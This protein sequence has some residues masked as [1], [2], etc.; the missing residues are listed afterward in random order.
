MG[1]I[2]L[3]VCLISARGLRQSTILWNRHWFAVGWT[4]PKN[5]YCTKID[6]SGSSNPVWK[7]KFSTLLDSD[8]GSQ[9]P[10]LQD[11]VLQ[12]E[13]Y[14][15]DPVFL[16]EKLQG[17][18]SIALREFLVKLHRKSEASSSVNGE[19]GSY[20][21]RKKGSGKPRGFVDVSIRVSEEGAEPSFYTG[22]EGG[23]VLMD[24]NNHHMDLGSENALAPAFPAGPTP[25]PLAAH[26]QQNHQKAEQPYTHP[27]PFPMN[28][29]DNR[30]G[31]PTYTPAS[32]PSYRGPSY[33]GP[34][35]A[36]HFPPPAL[37]PPQRAGYLPAAHARMDYN[38]AN[39]INMPSSGGAIGR[40][41][42]GRGFGLGVGAGA[43]AAAGAIV[44]GDSLFSGFDVP[45]G[46]QDPSLTISL[47]PLF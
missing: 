16:T 11:L 46:M 2:C 10:A 9:T 19:V 37:G 21:L 26:K 39:Y 17:T 41:G 5:K 24:N 4:D 35:L 40:G 45:V 23:I 44:Y 15:R 32:G 1:K 38:P 20:Q 36:P 31:G 13:V 34:Y 25:L 6:A 30:V 7:T 12:V 28:Y 3:E 14:S 47:D 42:G 8:A 43:A 33:R 27:A 22:N 29:A 18:A